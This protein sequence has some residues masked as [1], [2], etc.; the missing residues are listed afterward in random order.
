MKRCFTSQTA[1]LCSAAILLC[2]LPM[3]A[4][5]AEFRMQTAYEDI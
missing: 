4:L 1:M 5:A 3:Q 2:C